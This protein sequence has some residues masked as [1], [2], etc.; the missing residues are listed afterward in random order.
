MACRV[1][2][3]HDTTFLVALNDSINR[4]YPVTFAIVAHVVEG[5]GQHHALT[6]QL[7][8]RLVRVDHARVAHQLVEEAE[9]EQV[10]DGVFNTANVD[11]NRQP[12]V[13][14]FGIQHAFVV[15][16]AGIARVVP[17][18]LHKGIEGVGFA[19]RRH[20]VNGGFR[21]FGIGFDWAGDTVH[22]H[23]FRQNHRQLIFRGRQHGAVFQGHHWDGGAPVTL[24]GNAPVAQTVVY[25]TLANAFRGQLVS[26]GVEARFKVQTVEFAGVKQH[27]FLGQRLL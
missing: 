13:C 6:Q 18:R 15:L 23:V 21:P 16:R 22:D 9:V 2:R 27:A 4:R 14:G 1:L 20:T 25:F 10:H 19:Q 26:N 11:I 12:V 8:R 24:T 17:G 5:I 7:F 3:F